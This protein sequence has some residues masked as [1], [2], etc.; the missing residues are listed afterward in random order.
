MKSLKLIT[1]LMFVVLLNSCE[2][3]TEPEKTP[4]EIEKQ[5]K[6]DDL[7]IKLKFNLIKIDYDL[8]TKGLG[9]DRDVILDGF[10]K[11]RDENPTSVYSDSAKMYLDSLKNRF[12][13]GSLRP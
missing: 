12:D 13:D 2:S 10:Y 3:N 1:G 9:K 8:F 11:I 7:N 4:E 5:Q 6:I